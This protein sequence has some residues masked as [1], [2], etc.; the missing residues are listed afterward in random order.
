MRTHK[1]STRPLPD[2]ALL[3]SLTLGAALHTACGQLTPEPP[4]SLGQSAE[5]LTCP[6]GNGFYVLYYGTAASEIA[7]IRASRPNFVVVAN[8]DAAWPDQYHYDDPVARTGPTGIKVIAYIPMNYAR[9]NECAGNTTP[10][11]TCTNMSCKSSCNCLPIQ[12]RIDNAMS[13]GYDGV[14]FDETNSTYDAYNTSCYNTVKAHGADKLVIDNPGNIPATASIF[15]AADLVSVENKYDLPLPSFTGIASWRWL[16]IQGDPAD[17]AA[18]SLAD[19]QDRLDTF[20]SNGGFWYYSA[21]PHWQLPTWFDSFATWVQGL[22]SAPCATPS[23][24]SRWGAWNDGVNNFYRFSF[25]QPFTWYRVYIDSDHAAATGFA[26]AGIGADYLIENSTL[27]AHGG[28]GWNWTPV[29]SAGRTTTSNSIAWTVS[30]ATLGQAAY[31]NTDR[32]AFEAERAGGPL[33]N[34]GRYEHVYSASSGSIAGYV[35]Q[36]DGTNVYYQ[37]NF[38][39]PYTYKHVFIDTDT[40]S[41]TGYSYGGIGADYMI[42][43]NKLY[44]HSGGG[45]SWTNI[46]DT[47]ATGGST[48]TKSWAVARATL[49]ETASSGELADVVF[50]GSGGATEYAAPLY[51]HVYS[52]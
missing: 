25:A 49:G 46:A 26:T 51:H 28:G 48:G 6:A 42:E 36:N 40:N 29:G 19:A 15:N 20:R 16:A 45:W 5:A 10:S 43:N 34:T 38:A 39:S 17:Q 7:A 1:P 14:F 2:A 27:Y 23:Q 11:T 12:T 33:E 3:V 21:S 50:H 18:T 41:S 47:P 30:R 4:E 8:E 24:L 35:A 52:R 32:L 37:A 31:P 44:R 22:A 9:G 13:R